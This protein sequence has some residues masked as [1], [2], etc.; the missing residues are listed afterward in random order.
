MAT[1]IKQLMDE[2]HYNGRRIK[3]INSS[4]IALVPKKKNP[5]SLDDFRPI[6]LISSLYKILTKCLANKLKSVMHKIISPE[7]YLIVFLV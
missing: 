3:G 2:F 1:D 5:I 4:F 7:Q 6:S